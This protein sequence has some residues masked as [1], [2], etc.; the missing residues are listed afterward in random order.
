[1][2]RTSR[3]CPEVRS[4]SRTRFNHCR[5]GIVARFREAGFQPPS[6]DQLRNEAERNQAAVPELVRLAA[7]EGE[8]VQVSDAIFLH[9]DV[10][11]DLRARLRQELATGGRT[12]SQIREL[13][14]TTRKYAVPICEYLDRVGF[15]KREGDVRVLGEGGV[16]SDE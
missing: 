8:L 15:T 16:M 1:M 12:L 9:C 4:R 5:A 11:A 7:A 2:A 10:E 6:I 3:C 13:L 14:G